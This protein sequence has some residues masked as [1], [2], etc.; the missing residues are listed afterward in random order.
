MKP[1]TRSIGQQRDGHPR[2]PYV[3]GRHI[4]V[5]RS[6]Y[7][8]AVVLVTAASSVIATA[9]RTRMCNVNNVRFRLEHNRAFVLS[10]LR[11]AIFAV[12]APG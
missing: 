3:A 8:L 7:D 10:L 12:C 2:E 6:V 11:T 4:Q 5:C 9:A 1:R